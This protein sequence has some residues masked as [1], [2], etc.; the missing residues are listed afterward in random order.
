MTTLRNSLWDCRHHAATIRTDPAV[1][2]RVVALTSNRAA[3][4]KMATLLH[5]CTR[6]MLR[7]DTLPSFRIRRP[8]LANSS[9]GHRLRAGGASDTSPKPT[10]HSFRSART[11]FFLSSA[12][13][14]F[15]ARTCLNVDALWRHGHRAL[16][17]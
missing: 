16:R 1:S 17:C 14:M 13:K 7:R 4:I 5:P 8:G 15:L 9:R 11:S 6:S 2:S 12:G 10:D 3:N